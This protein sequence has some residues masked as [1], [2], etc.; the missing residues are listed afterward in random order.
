MGHDKKIFKYGNNL[1]KRKKKSR[2]K[3]RQEKFVKTYRQNVDNFLTVCYRYL[4]WLF[5][6]G[7]PIKIQTANPII[8]KA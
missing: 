8:L 6:C 7:V 2:K 5:A 3:N 4:H 1:Q